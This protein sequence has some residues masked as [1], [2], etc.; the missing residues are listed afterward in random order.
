MS[1]ID[2]Q[3]V[4]PILSVEDGYVLS[5]RGE[6]TVLFE[7]SLPEVFTVSY[8][9]YM[10]MHSTWSKVLRIL[11]V[12][13]IVHKQDFYNTKR[14]NAQ[15]LRTH[16]SYLDDAYWSFFDG[17]EYLLHRCYIYFTKTNLK[18]IETSGLGSMLCKS[19]YIGSKINPDEQ[20]QFLDA[21]EQLVA[22][23]ND[24]KVMHLRRLTTEEIVGA[25]GQLGLYD[26]LFSLGGETLGDVRFGEKLDD[27]M[28]IG[29]D[30]L[31]IISLSNLDQL[32]DTVS[33]SIE[34]SE[35][36][37]SVTSLMT[38]MMFPIGLGLQIPHILNQYIILTDSEKKKEEVESRQKSLIAMSQLSV[39]NGVN[40]EY[41]DKFLMDMRVNNIRAVECH[42][43]VMT[44]G[45]DNAVLKNN[46]LEISK[47]LTPNGFVGKTLSLD[48]P[49]V[50]WASIPGNG[51]DLPH[52]ETFITGLEQ[53]VCLFS[54]ESNHR[55][56]PSDFHLT[57]CDRLT[58]TPVRIDISDL[59]YK[60][61][62]ITNKNKFILGPS[63]SGKSFFT[64]NMVRQYYDQGAHILLVD[65]GHSYEYQCQIVHERTGG[66]DGIY[67]TASEEHPLSFNPF[68]S[69]RGT[70]DESSVD[71]IES[72]IAFL[73]KLGERYTPSERRFVQES[74]QD[75][76]NIVVQEHEGKGSFNGYYEY[77]KGPYIEKLKDIKAKSGLEVK[78][79][80]FDYG[81]MIHVLTPFYKGGR[82]ET[83]LN[84]EKGSDIFDKR[85]VVFELEN[86]QD[87]PILLPLTTIIIMDGYMNKVKKIDGKKVL[88]IEEAWKA[89][90]NDKFAEYIKGVFKTVRKHDGEA[91]V[92]TQELDDLLSSD[93]VKE[94]IITQSDCK[95]L[96]DQS[97][98]HKRFD[99]IR[100]FLGLTE[101]QQAEIF[102][103]NLHNDYSNGRNQY[104]EAWIG[105]G[106]SRSGVFAVEVSEVE[107]LAFGTN[108]NEKYAL[109]RIKEERGVT[110]EE[111]IE[112]YIKQ[113][114][115]KGS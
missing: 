70:F 102:S 115:N 60:Q 19:D 2:Y 33:L 44:W 9:D 7:L 22:I 13:T 24:T 79:S 87:N 16:R 76:L 68:Y 14:F 85:F 32:P 35:Y 45:P 47:R 74:I 105:L 40:A 46:K 43:N 11:P 110:I 39:E 91:I 48:V 83:L 49:V 101:Q 98:Y 23:V 18:Q 89:I 73:W 34:S 5:K 104:R 1:A 25:E 30:L 106:T 65:I 66:K 75:Y 86:I 62:I 55:D 61:G 72:I 93:V 20:Q 10:L 95:I 21:I 82:Y 103:I 53:A 28:R 64:N 97:K 57:L 94:T 109:N 31:S 67:Y 8:N 37:T 69:E 112:I 96:L 3:S 54:S 38:S 50:F 56:S 88:I 99:E 42:V 51:G 80:D 17:R 26:L 100:G 114:K 58:G 111:A 113:Q 77:L 29:D 90:M 27:R 4:F 92:V 71:T 108:A 36:S 6:V 59:P 84:N 78:V 41:C 81:N 63:G 52:E 107:R 15:S 12:P